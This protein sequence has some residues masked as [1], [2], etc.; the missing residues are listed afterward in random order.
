MATVKKV[1]D[2]TISISL[3]QNSFHE[4][5]EVIVIFGAVIYIVYNSSYKQGFG[6]RKEEMEILAISKNH[7]SI[8]LCYVKICTHILKRIIP[9]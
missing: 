4:V 2:S 3:P 1:S 9:P 8:Q 5:D 6:D 7:N